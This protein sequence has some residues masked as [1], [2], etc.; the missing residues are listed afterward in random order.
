MED[1]KLVALL[2]ERE[3]R[4]MQQMA[5]QMALQIQ[6]LEQRMTQQMQAD[7]ES[8]TQQMQS[9]REFSVKLFENLKREVQASVDQGVQTERRLNL[10]FDQMNARL[11]RM[12]TAWRI[13]RRWATGV[14]DRQMQSD[15]VIAGL[16]REMTDL[17]ERVVAL[18]KKQQ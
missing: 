10:R 14:D 1:E 5:Q 7:R 8:L 15:N 13:G 9:D 2:Q 11:T 17:R 12:D 16:V 3:D 4:M 18:E 6:H